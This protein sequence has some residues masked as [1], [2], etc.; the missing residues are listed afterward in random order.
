MYI[1]EGPAIVANMFGAWGHR[2]PAGKFVVVESGEVNEGGHGPV[3]CVR[4][5]FNTRQEAQEAIEASTLQEA[6]RPANGLS[7]PI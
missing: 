4:G 3:Q 1:L 6:T 5:L 7:M 2:V